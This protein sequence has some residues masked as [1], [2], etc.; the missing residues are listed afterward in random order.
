MLKIRM[1]R[2]H[3]NYRSGD[4]IDIPENPGGMWVAHGLAELVTDPLSEA[5]DMV[6]PDL[7]KPPVEVFKK[8]PVKGKDN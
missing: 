4:V 8:K 5:V 7:E 3:G 2:T 6:A 1:L